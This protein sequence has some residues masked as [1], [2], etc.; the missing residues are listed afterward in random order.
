MSGCDPT[1]MTAAERLTEIARILAE[2]YLRLRAD[3][4]K[5]ARDR[6]EPAD[7]SVEETPPDSRTKTLQF[8]PG[9]D[10]CQCG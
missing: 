9:N 2:G 6:P 8:P 1:E 5:G 7:P 4:R 3:R 10:S